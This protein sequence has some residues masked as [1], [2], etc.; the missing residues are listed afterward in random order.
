MTGFISFHDDRKFIRVTDKQTNVVAYVHKDSVTIQR[1]NIKCFF[2]K[3]NTYI[4]YFKYTEILYPVTKSLED[5]LTLLIT[6]CTTEITSQVAVLN[7]IETGETVFAIDV[8]DKNEFMVDESTSNNAFSTYE[9]RAVTM[10]LSNILPTQ[11]NSI[12]R[13]SKQYIH[14]P[15]GKASI[16]MISG[17]LLRDNTLTTASNLINKNLLTTENHVK[18]RIGVFD[19]ASYISDDLNDKVQHGNGVYF[20]YYSESNVTEYSN[21]SVVL[22]KNNEVTEQ[23]FQTDWNTDP[24][25][26]K[27][28][29]GR[30]LRVGEQNSFVLKCGNLPNTKISVGCMDHGSVIIVHEF[31]VDEEDFNWYSKLPVRWELSQKNTDS[32]A[33]ITD[34]PY[35]LIQNRAVVISNESYYAE[36]KY[37]STITTPFTKISSVAD[38]NVLFEIKLHDNHIR[39]KLKLLKINIINVYQGTSVLSWKVVKNGK[40]HH[41][42]WTTT[43]TYDQHG[44]EQSVTSRNHNHPSD[45]TSIVDLND[46]TATGKYIPHLQ[47]KSKASIFFV[48]SSIDSNNDTTN[49]ITVENGEVVASGYI[50]QNSL[51]EIDLTNQM[52]VLLADITGYSDRLALLVEYINSPA[53]LQANITWEEFE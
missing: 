8:Q 18:S 5:L 4:R 9:N 23:V 13:Q 46:T 1:D 28:A 17:T 40:L 21:L 25:N 20:E 2:I 43:I 24:M 36:K 50:A 10:S 29:S 3:S 19:D 51:T 16:T 31:D 32:A 22:R 34:S 41:Y 39:S 42:D 6:L 33:E 15:P 44:V 47:K 38:K 12:V 14:T 52:N 11:I 48:E 53:E 27:G 26:G 7:E 37:V 35:E 45:D 49:Y 30:V